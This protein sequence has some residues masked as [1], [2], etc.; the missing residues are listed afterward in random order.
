MTGILSDIL[1]YLAVSAGYSL[2]QLASLCDFDLE[3]IIIP[4][5]VLSIGNGA[6]TGSTS[7]RNPR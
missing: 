6:F 4:P 1:A 5:S 3:E 2:N 7:Y